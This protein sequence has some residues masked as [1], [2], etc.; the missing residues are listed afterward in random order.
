[1]PAVNGSNKSETLS[2][3]TDS[4]TIYGNNGND[5]VHG[6]GG[7]DV[8]Q[9]GKGND[10]LNGGGGVDYLFGGEGNDVFSF[11]ELGSHNKQRDIVQDYVDGE[12]TFALSGVE[13]F[14]DLIITTG[15]N[16]N[17]RMVTYVTDGDDTDGGPALSFRIRGD[18]A[19]QLDASDFAFL[20]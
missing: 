5:H 19:D 13:S 6:L 10:T 1:M 4:D 17:G 15:L 16:A 18:V 20:A 11:T 9:G 3:T 8:L 7:F 14:D 2:G 12:D